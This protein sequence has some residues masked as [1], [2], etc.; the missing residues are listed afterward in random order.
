VGFIAFCEI[1]PG[2]FCLLRDG[3]WWKVCYAHADGRCEDLLWADTEGLG[4]SELSMFVRWYVWGMKEDWNNWPVREW[5]RAEV[6]RVLREEGV[7]PDYYSEESC[8]N[9]DDAM[10]YE[11]QEDGWWLVFYTERGQVFEFAW[12]R[13]EQQAL[14]VWLVEIL[15]SHR[16][17]H[18]PPK[19]AGDA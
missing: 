12:T 16:R 11:R 3:E 2:A 10:C 17:Y 19:E 1:N 7:N 14:R 18:H 8:F 4:V 5:T 9:R 13:T 6:E 15:Y